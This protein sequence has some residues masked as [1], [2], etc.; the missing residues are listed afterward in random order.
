[1]E[2]HSTFNTHH[3]KQKKH[4]FKSYIIIAFRNLWR[5]KIFSMINMAGLTIGISVFLLILQYISAERDTNRFHKIIPN[6]TGW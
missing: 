6:Y 5:N 2:L 4:M 3:S 1:M